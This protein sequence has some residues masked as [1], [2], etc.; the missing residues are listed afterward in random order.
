MASRRV[1][2]P[3]SSQMSTISAS[4]QEGDGEDVTSGSRKC[5]CG[6]AA[7]LK[8]STTVRN[9]GRRF[10]GCPNFVKGN[11]KRCG[12]F[13]WVDNNSIEVAREEAQWSCIVQDLVKA[14]EKKEDDI[15]YLRYILGV[16]VLFCVLFRFGSGYCCCVKRD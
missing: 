11:I 16:A 9:P 7:K 5:N 1:R 6:L 4:F 8:T 10:Y 13:E 14:L 3:S 2:V 12:Y 15:R